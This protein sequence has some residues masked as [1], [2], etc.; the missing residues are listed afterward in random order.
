MAL[1]HFSSWKRMVLFSGLRFYFY[2]KQCIWEKDTASVSSLWNEVFILGDDLL[3]ALAVYDPWKL[4]INRI[5]NLY[6]VFVLGNNLAFFKWYF[7]VFEK[8]QM[9]SQPC[10]S[11]SGLWGALCDSG[12]YTKHAESGTL[13]ITFHFQQ[14]GGS[15]KREVSGRK[16]KKSVS[17]DPNIP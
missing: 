14:A 5:C 12:V 15:G 3:K 13:N 10:S 2:W 6:H 7:T 11:S 8:K 9:P 4:P 1:Y 17:P 16:R